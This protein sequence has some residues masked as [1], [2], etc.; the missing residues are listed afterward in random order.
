[1]KG[2]GKR[3]R[4]MSGVGRRDYNCQGM[5]LVTTHDLLPPPKSH[6]LTAHS[7]MNSSVY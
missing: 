1:M 2:E 4:Q 7:V 3:E 5:L 6:P